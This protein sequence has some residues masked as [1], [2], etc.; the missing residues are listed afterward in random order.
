MDIIL[1][2]VIEVQK[3]LVAEKLL[4]SF[5]FFLSFVLYFVL[6]HKIIIN[7]IKEISLK[8]QLKVAV[9]EDD[10]S[11]NIIKRKKSTK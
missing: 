6:L 8:L 2:Q 11:R 9:S 1:W 3:L 7:D 10:K 5:C 4:S